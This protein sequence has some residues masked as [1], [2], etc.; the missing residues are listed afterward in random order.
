MEQILLKLQKHN[1]RMSI[2]PCDYPERC[3][4]LY[5]R[6]PTHGYRKTINLDEFRYIRHG[7]GLVDDV[8]ID[9]IRCHL[10]D[11]IA[12]TDKFKEIENKPI[13]AEYLK[14]L[15]ERVKFMTM[16]KQYVDSL[17]EQITNYGGEE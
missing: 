6:T 11:F 13:D 16:H 7:G 10:D 12:E 15:E 17:E 8:I 9:I 5:F 1:I 2:E 14:H 3:V 4:N